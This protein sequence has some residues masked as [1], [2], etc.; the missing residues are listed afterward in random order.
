[1]SE[2]LRLIHAI[3][4]N[5]IYLEPLFM[6]SQEVAKELPV[7]CK[8]FKKQDAV[9]AGV[10]A[11]VHLEERMDSDLYIHYNYY[12]NCYATAPFVN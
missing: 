12:Y 8:R 1:M 3:L 6:N 9:R 2:V 4:E 7:D 10:R 11:C 5:W